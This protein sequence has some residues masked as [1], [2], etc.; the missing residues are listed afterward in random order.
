MSVT[1]RSRN[2]AQTRWTSFSGAEAPEVIPTIV[3]SV[4]PGLVDLGLV[5]DQVAT[6]RRRARAVSTSRFEL[7]EFREPITSSRSIWSS[8]SLTAHWRLEVA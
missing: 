4:D 7:D 1:P 3:I 2:Q 6:A 5:V 8:I